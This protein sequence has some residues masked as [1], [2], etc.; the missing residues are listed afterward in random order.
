L[1][2]T[3]VDGVLTDGR[4]YYG[5]GGEALKAFDAKD[6]MGLRLLLDA[7]IDVAVITARGGAPLER[8]LADLRITNLLAGCEDKGAAVDELSSRLAIPPEAIAFVGDDLLDLP[9][10]SRAG[11][12]IT[13]ADGHPQVRQRA[14]WVT[15]APGGRGAIREIADG[16][17]SA[18]RHAEAPEFFVVIPARYAATRLPGKP[19]RVIAGRPMIAHVWERGVA[20][21]AAQVL[22]AADDERVIEAVEQLGGTAMLTSPDHESGTDRLAEVAQRMRWPDDAIVVNL[23]GDEPCMDPGLIRQVAR[24]VAEHTAAGVATLATPIREAADL[25]SPDVVK[26]VLDDRGFARYFSRAPIPWARDS[27]GRGLDAP[28]A[29]PDGVQYLRHLGL[30]AYRCGVLRRLAAEPRRA[31]ELAESLEQLRALAI[32]VEIHV[33]V[34]DR[35]PAHGVD[36]EADVAR[37]ER[38]LAERGA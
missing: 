9:A 37:A 28:G 1:L 17:L 13:V 18:R 14:D 22:V 33:T 2:I 21:G 23:Q 31:A 16:I 15:A 11:V 10:L 27:F 8:R 30:Y 38:V 7:G 26:V 12:A 35:A 24:S 5:D 3:D 34:V 4:L 29:L 36:T 25:F 19:L 32:G 20:A 6:G